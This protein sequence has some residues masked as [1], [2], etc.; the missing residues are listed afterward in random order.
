[1]WHGFAD[2]ALVK[3]APP[4]VVARGE[5][6]YLYDDTGRRYL[7]ASAGL[8]FCN[9]GHG[10]QEIADAAQRQLATLAAYS[11][12]GVYT[13]APA[14]ELAERLSQLTPTSGA[15]VF[16]SSGGSDSNDTMIKLVR[17]YWRVMGQPER[18]VIV[19]R[20]YSYH[21]GHMGSTGIGGIALDY[22][23]FGELIDDTARIP[24]DSSEALQRL[25][26]EMG[27]DR[28]AAF[29]LEPIIAAGGVRFPPD[30]Y[31]ER[32][33]KICRDNDII[34]VA[35]EVVT[36]FGRS[37]DW[38]ASS[39]FGLEPDIV[40]C[41]KGLTSGYVPLGALIVGDRVSAPFYDGRAG[42]FN[43]G[44]T[45]SG[46]PGGAAVAL[47][48][49]AILEREQLPAHVRDIET[50]MP[51]LLRP[52]SEHP[53]VHEVRTGPAFMA[54]VEFEPSMVHDNPFV[55]SAVAAAM[56]EV[57][58]LTRSLVEGQIQFSPPLVAGDEQVRE[59][60]DAALQAFAVVEG[61]IQ[62]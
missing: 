42:A 21:G 46:H 59:F 28:I 45:Y 36:G 10:R 24:W 19:S 33:A 44:Y 29:I 52:L 54:A 15:A 22:E 23:G 32:I 41:A 56:R 38:F 50:R 39:R 1:M 57:G 35:D 2:M 8:W 55:P 12:F 40:V 18:R 3:D 11:T 53:L 62:A 13:N 5:G 43:H 25:I 51:E 14:E 27:R 16:F 9:V 20:S 61:R 30:G 48:N 60:V 37:G 58:V 31:L 47:A 4:F 34:L 26:D 49:L 7:D 17:R 6:A